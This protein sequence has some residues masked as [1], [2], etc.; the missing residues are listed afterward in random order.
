VVRIYLTLS[1][2]A[3]ENL[4]RL[5][6]R[7]LRNPRMQAQFLLEQAIRERCDA[8]AER[9]GAERHTGRAAVTA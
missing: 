2:H 4:V 3:A 8:P 6:D 5:A 7:E 9:K 1:S